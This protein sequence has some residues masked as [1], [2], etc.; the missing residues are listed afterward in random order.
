MGNRIPDDDKPADVTALL[1]AWRQGDAVAG[2]EALGVV[3]QELRR[4]AAARLRAERAGHTLS[5]TEVVH[6]TYLR[7]ATQHRAWQNRGQFFGLACQMMRRVL[8]DYAR[9]RRRAKR[10]APRVTLTE[11]VALAP[12]LD[13]DLLAVDA[14]LSDLAAIDPRRSR[15]VELRF[16]G[17]LSL[18]ECADALS[19]SIAT[20]KRDWR[21]ARAWLYRQLQPWNGCE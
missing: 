15:L 9:T 13:L 4:R 12:A 3:Y 1:N 20:A 5:P 2:D 6:E 7:L 8:V 10:A 11:G 18:E 17:G 19:I 14:A 16:F 21:F